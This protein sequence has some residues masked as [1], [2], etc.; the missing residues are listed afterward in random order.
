MGNTFG[1]EGGL[2]SALE[3]A[4]SVVNVVQDRLE[5]LEL[6]HEPE[7]MWPFFG[8]RPDNY[9]LEDYVGDWKMYAKAASEHVLKNNKYGLDETRF[10]QA[11]TFTGGDDPEWN[12]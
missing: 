11:L 6:G 5:C 3:V 4:R 2:E 1:K 8:H 7:L 10:F 12:M 9:S